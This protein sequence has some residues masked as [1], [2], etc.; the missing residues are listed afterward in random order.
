MTC[1]AMRN[2]IS[3]PGSESGPMPCDG[4]GGK[5]TAPSGPEAA[6]ASPSRR[7]AKASASKILA[8]SGPTSFGSLRSAGLTASLVSSL[9]TRARGSILYELTWKLVATPS[10]VLTYR[11]RASPK[12]RTS[13]SG[14]TGWPTPTTPSGGQTWP[15]GTSATG[16]RPDG[17]KAT[18]NLEQ[19]AMLAGWATPAAT[20][21]P[22]TP[23]TMAK[24]LAFR[25]RNA[26]QNS[27]PLY[28]GD[29]ANLAGWRTP[30]SLSP[31]ALRGSG[32]EPGHRLAGGHTVN[33]QDEV[34]LARWSELIGSSA[35][36]ASGGRL[37][38]TH[39][40][41]LLRLPTA[42]D[43]CAATAMLSTRKRRRAS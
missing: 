2:A 42:W 37:D 12:A 32:Q 4:R 34:L 25:K 18:V 33:L 14:S 35:E 1:E 39:P 16:R 11:L 9:Q 7:P 28:L 22:R 5:M 13:G 19:V 41:W 3:S 38:P 17:S 20:D 30:T 15:P 24:C 8:T 40:R 36:T 29:Q 23:E 6:P 27:V 10:Q 26:N 21:R 43:D 31:N